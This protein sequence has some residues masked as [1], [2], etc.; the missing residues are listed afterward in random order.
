M[1]T[2]RECVMRRADGGW[3]MAV[4]T[5]TEAAKTWKCGRAT[6]YR[7]LQSGELS[8]SDMPDGGRGV[9][10][11]E[12][13]RVF[14]VVRPPD[15]KSDTVG[16]DTGREL[17]R[18]NAHLRELL[19]VKDEHIETLKQAMRLL[20]DKR[21]PIAVEV[22]S[23]TPANIPAVLEAERTRVM[24]LEAQLAAER[25]RGFFSRVFGGKR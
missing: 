8:G 13:H 3:T 11:A 5:I 10:T 9:D 6:I 4:V 19:I 21:P 7:K 20:E 18:E 25:S 17:I 23:P 22:E 12:L 1:R 2:V 24:E 15:G 14:G 16:Q